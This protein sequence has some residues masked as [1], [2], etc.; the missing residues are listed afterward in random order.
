MTLPLD[1]P[2]GC[3][4]IDV[5]AGK[6]MADVA[7]SLWDDKGTLLA[8]ARGGTA[9]KLFPCGAGGAAKLD[10]EA[11]ESPGPFA[12]ELRKDA[13]APPLL[14]SHP[15]AAARL[16]SRLEAS[17]DLSGAAGAANAALVT[18][19][20]GSRKGGSLPAGGSGCVE[21]IAALD[22]GGSGI[23]LVLSDSATGEGVVTRSR[24]VASDR[25]CSRALGKPA[26][27]QLR[28]AAGKTDALVLLRMVSAP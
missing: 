12:V 15:I 20:S 4:R 2:A 24:Y 27:Y 17:G 3:A 28:L 8:E 6:P 10:L 11:M 23:D 5:L 26:S 22:A 1:I 18:L 7:A 21:V 13:A 14:V 16:L 25:I 9:A 19:E